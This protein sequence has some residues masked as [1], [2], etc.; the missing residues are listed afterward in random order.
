LIEFFLSHQL[1]HRHFKRIGYCN[2]GFKARLGGI[3]DPLGNNCS[4]AKL[5]NIIETNADMLKK[6]YK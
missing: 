5:Q 3:G 6:L 1:L 2:E 4:M